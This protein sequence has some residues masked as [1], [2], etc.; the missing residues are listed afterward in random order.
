LRNSERRFDN[1]YGEGR[2][3]ARGRAVF[4]GKADASRATGS[5]AWARASRR[6]CRTSDRSAVPARCSASLL[7]PT[8]QMMPINRP[9]ASGQERRQ[10]SSTAAG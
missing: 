2:R 1:G 9:G 5:D 3:V 6:I 8:S 4:E 10:P 7:D